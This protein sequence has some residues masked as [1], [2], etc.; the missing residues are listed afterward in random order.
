MEENYHSTLHTNL[1]LNKIEVKKE[2]IKTLQPIYYDFDDASINEI[3][4]NEM[5]KIVEIMNDNPELILEASAFTDS[6][7]SNDYN[8]K[9]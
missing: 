9:F 4:A 8:R 7:G 2:I 5:D 1:N 6:R 3:A